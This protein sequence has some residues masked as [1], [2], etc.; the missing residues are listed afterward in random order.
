MVLRARCVLMR[1]CWLPKWPIRTCAKPRASLRPRFMGG[2]VDTF[3]RGELRGGATALFGAAGP[4]RRSGGGRLG[5]RLHLAVCV[6]GGRDGADFAA[7]GP[8]RS[9]NPPCI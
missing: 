4:P 6:A 8:T 7:P 1:S 3:G 9:S 5:L 2:V